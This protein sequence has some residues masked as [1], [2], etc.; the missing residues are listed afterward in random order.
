LVAPP[1]AAHELPLQLARC[2]SSPIATC[3]RPA[4]RLCSPARHLCSPAHRPCSPCAALAAPR[5]AFAA[6]RAAPAACAP[7]LQPRAPPLQPRALP[8]HSARRPCSPAR[9]PYSPEHCL[10]RPTCRPLRPA[11]HPC[12][13]RATRLQP[14]CRRCSLRATPAARTPPTCGPPAAPRTATLP[15]PPARCLPAARSPPLPPA[16]CLPAA[17][18][19]PLEARSP[20]TSSPHADP[21]SSLSARCGPLAALCRPRAAPCSPLAAPCGLLAAPCRPLT[22]PCGPL[23]APCSLRTAPWQPARRPFACP[24]Y[25]LRRPAPA[26]PVAG[27]PSRAS[28]CPACGRPIQFDMWLDDLQLY[29]LSDSRDIVLL[30]DHMSGASLA[31]P[32]TADSATCS[33]WLTR[34]AAALLAI[35][36]YLP[37]A[38]CAHFR[39]HK[40]A[41]ALYDDELAR[42]SSPAN[43]A[44]GRLLLPYLFPE[45]SAFAT[46]ENL[47]THL[48]TSDARY[49]AALPAEDHF[50]A[51]YPT[52]LTIDLLEQ[53]LLAA[54]TSVVAVGAA[55]GTPRT[56]FSEGCSP[57]PL[58]P[59]YASA[60]AADIL[61]AEDI[62]ATSAS[63][64]RHNSKGKG[65]RSGGGGSGGG[66]GGGNGNGGG[67]GGGGSGGSG[68]GSGGFGGGGAGSGGSGGS[69]GSR[70][71]A[72][73]R[74]GSCGGQRLQQQ[75]WSET[76]SPQQLCEWFS[77]RGASG[78][79]VSWPYV[80]CTG[81]RAGQTCGKPH[82]HHR[83]FSRLDDAWRAEF[84]DEAER[85]RRAEQ[86]S[87]TL[88]P[89]SAPVP[90]RLADPSGGPVL[91]RSST[92]LPCS[93]VPSSSLLGI[94]LPSFS[95]NLSSTAALQDAMVTTIT[96]GGQRV[97]ICAC[98]RTGRH[99]AT[100]SRR[101]GSSL[102]T[103][104]S[105]PPQVAASLQVSASG[106]VAPPCS[107]RLLSHQTLLWH[108]RLGRP[109][110]P[111]L[112][113]MH[114]RLLVSGLP[115]SLP[116]IPPSPA[117]P[118]LPC[119]E[120]WQRAAPHS[121]FPPTTT[122]LQTLHMD[123]WGPARVSGQGRER[124]FLLVVDDFTQ[125]TTPTLVLM[126]PVLVLLS[127]GPAGPGPAGPGSAGPS[128]A[129]PGP[130]GPGP[131][132]P[133]PAGTAGLGPS[134]GPGASAA[135][136]HA[137]SK[138]MTSHDFLHCA[139][140]LLP[141]CHAHPP[142]GAVLPELP[143]GHRSQ[144]PAASG[145]MDGPV[146]WRRHMHAH[147]GGASGGPLRVRPG[148]RVGQQRD[149]GDGSAALALSI[150]GRHGDL[151][152][153]PL[154]HR[155]PRCLLYPTFSLPTLSSHTSFEGPQMFMEVAGWHALMLHSPPPA[156]MLPSAS[157]DPA[158]AAAA[159]AAPPSSPT[160]AP[161]P[162]SAG[163]PASSPS[164]APS[165]LGGVK[166]R[167][168]PS[169]GTGAN[170]L[171][172]LIDGCV[173]DADSA[174]QRCRQLFTNSSSSGS[175]STSSGDAMSL[176]MRVASLA[177][178]SCFQAC[179]A[180]LPC[181]SFLPPDNVSCPQVRCNSAALRYT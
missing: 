153:E 105:K 93:A 80:I 113:G 77:Q 78:G 125:Y 145:C 40:T 159:S 164:A 126:L 57:S 31:P 51:L 59:S 96:P 102:Y 11:R 28:P 6:L 162:S 43:A 7:P 130:A 37:L 163:A 34:D 48:R 36:N 58:A 143:G 74:G 112:R 179:D 16:C 35:R 94:H 165:P 138:H 124:Y 99:L 155:H 73:Q 68:G 25:C 84:G 3:S 69:G 64:K 135:N 149:G 167:V 89:L 75:R 83:C 139:C 160:P 87:T 95:T 9:R 168:R 146:V 86:L 33:Q 121:S 63:G 136:A 70:G 29:L 144:R 23:A 50:L 4:R 62:G 44:L 177:L 152:M 27:H 1:L 128:P 91:A 134:S 117:P 140:S 158:A 108:H 88:T 171:L 5:N 110:L 18:S 14:T 156:S 161:P 41:K 115:R 119:I 46:V 76:P 107:C 151:L 109:S 56:P 142:P 8:L 60:V 176:P 20:P 26:R 38:E 79:S 72:V 97:S 2:P 129:S 49:R 92:V 106:P 30:F 10:L 178:G 131:A 71:G 103:L 132:G 137:H 42:Y 55:R 15:P 61:G 174:L 123:V 133:G 157:L 141:V 122:P 173:T 111:R 22:A 172:A 45:L 181:T 116:P 114:S 85:P 180:M 104:A 47:D 170:V 65:G 52:H 21:C 100:F 101:P 39:K 19:L 148:L 17:R 54:E 90:V 118:C 66:R 67:S 127:P 82:T 32:A 147:H 81:D 12:S 24:P 154:L 53:H 120:G 175:S 13:P 98:T 169:N 150:H 166:G